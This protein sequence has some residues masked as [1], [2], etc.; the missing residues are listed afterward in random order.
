MSALSDSPS[1]GKEQ[2]FQLKMSPNPSNEMFF[3][4]LFFPPYFLFF[5]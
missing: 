3:V 2:G 5:I 1:V 4:V